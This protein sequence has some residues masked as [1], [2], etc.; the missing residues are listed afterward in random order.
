M[1]AEQLRKKL[2]EQGVTEL[3]GMLHCDEQH[4]GVQRTVATVAPRETELSK[5]SRPRLAFT[6]YVGE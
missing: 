2:V 6:A 1:R 5:P 4:G 3:A